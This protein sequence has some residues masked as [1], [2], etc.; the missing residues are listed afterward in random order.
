M[1]VRFDRDDDDRD[2][3]AA[4][5]VGS[6]MQI[7]A[8]ERREDGRLALAVQAGERL[9]V[10]GSPKQETPYTVV[11]GALLPDDAALP[12]LPEAEAAFVV[13]QQQ[14]R[15]GEAGAASSPA[16]ER[17]PTDSLTRRRARAVR[18]RAT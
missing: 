4:P 17:A 10:L 13:E 3:P 1:D 16:L 7:S 6:L 8:A 9:V 18:R 12:L 2:V 5:V 14:A 15:G 11:S